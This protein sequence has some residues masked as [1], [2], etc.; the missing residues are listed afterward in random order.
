MN[1]YLCLN[2]TIL[3]HNFNSVHL[4]VFKSGGC[5]EARL[6][7]TLIARLGVSS[8]RVGVTAEIGEDP[9]L[10]PSSCTST[11]SV[12]LVL[13]DVLALPLLKGLGS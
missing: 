5:L 2:S 9:V 4:L 3:N 8:D 7:E 10:G 12:L 11:R 13:E 1:D 6:V